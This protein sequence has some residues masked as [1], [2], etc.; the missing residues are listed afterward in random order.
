MKLFSPLNILTLVRKNALP[1]LL[2]L[3]TGISGITLSQREFAGEHWRWTVSLDG[4]GYYAQLPSLFIYND[5]S[6]QSIRKIVPEGDTLQPYLNK[7]G[8]SKVNKYYCGEAVLLSPFFAVAHLWTKA[9]GKPANGYSRRYYEAISYAAIFYLLAGLL[10]LWLLLRSFGLKEFVV[11]VVLILFVYGTNL[12]YY[13]VWQPSMSHV[14]SFFSIALLLLLQRKIIAGQYKLL[15]PATLLMGIVVLIRP[16]NIV[17]LLGFL[18]MT[19]DKE[20]LIL[21]WRQLMH[22]IG[23]TIGALLL[24][25]SVVS[26]QFLFYY[27]QTGKFFIWS[28]KNEGFDFSN[29]VFFSPLLEFEKGLFIYFPVLLLSLCGLILMG[30]LRK[31]LLAVGTAAVI[32]LMMYINGS[33]SCPHFGYSYGLRPYI[34]I[35]PFF[36]LPAAFLISRLLSGYR[37][38]IGIP[39]F[40]FFIL[41]TSIQT[42]Q[43]VTGIFPQFEMSANKYRFIW[44][45]TNPEYQGII[46]RQFETTK[47]NVLIHHYNNCSTDN[48]ELK[49]TAA[50]TP[51]GIPLFF[52]QGRL[53]FPP[54][55][56]FTLRLR[57]ADQGKNPTVDLKIIGLRNGIITWEQ[58]IVMPSTAAQ[59]KEYTWFG[60][61]SHTVDY[62]DAVYAILSDK[63]GTA[64][65]DFAEIRFPEN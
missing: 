34:D 5:P 14:Y 3:I 11:F 64:K 28:Y 60:E 6:Y 15:L 59:D 17:V 21:F 51:E 40:T 47:Q 4:H 65:I 18:F 30:F 25:L 29:P 46:T 61:F 13:A 8:N 38:L 49:G 10:A 43:V 58:N 26:L 42:Y 22:R 54:R 44:G 41:L 39:L 23:H 62:E 57:Y 20:K 45:K 9:D 48:P 19:D 55:K 36:I 2:L 24:F 63:S 16:V 27:W 56:K 50:I 12:F 35:Y 53:Y 7:V 33:W 1:A 32:I 52:Y 31:W 37:L